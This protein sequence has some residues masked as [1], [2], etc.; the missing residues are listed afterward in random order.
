[1]V[2]SKPGTRTVRSVAEPARRLPVCGSYDVV[3]VGGGIGGIAAAVAA[4]RNGASVCLI[5]KENAL[6][7]LATLANVIVYLPL[8]DGLG[9]Q[10]IGG[11]GEELLKLSVKDLRGPNRGMRLQ[12]IPECWR[13]GGDPAARLK[14]RYVTWFN[15]ADYMLDLE[16][17]IVA[18]GVK[19]YYDTRFCTITRK[20]N[21]VA[22]VIVEN[23]SGRSAILCKTVVDSSGDADVCALAGEPVDSVDTNVRAG[24]FYYLRNNVVYLNPLTKEPD[25][26]CRRS[27]NGGSFYAGDKADDVTA[28]TLDT[29]QL[30]REFLADLRRQNPTEEI[31][32]LIL[33]LIPGFRMTRR[34]RGAVELEETDERRWFDDTVGMTGDWRTNGP[35]YYLP[36]RCLAGVRNANLITAGRCISSGRT[37]WDMARVI[38]TCAVTGE[39]AGTA[40]AMAAARTSGRIMDL[41][42]PDL[43]AQLRRQN[44]IIDRVFAKP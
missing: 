18:E 41:N 22:A 20:A 35:I 15:P 33:T 39:A 17:L 38:P 44:V 29:R 42:I 12:P 40:A 14:E 9:H 25:R 31:Y 36:L 1:M 27:Q 10:V 13:S 37:A 5:E 24:W 28:Q 8:C 19:L 7:G 2:S 16:A 26:Y 34:L 21:R 4:A 32:P 6:G 43:Q 30:Q 11:L 3:V 23:K